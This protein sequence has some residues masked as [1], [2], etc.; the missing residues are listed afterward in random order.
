MQVQENPG[1]PS[2][3][4]APA[5]ATPAA[6]TPAAA[7]PAAAATPDPN[8]PNPAP[9]TPAAAEQAPAPTRPDWAPETFWDATK[10]ELKGEDIGKI[11]ASHAERQADVITDPTKATIKSDLKGKDGKPI[12][13]NAESPL[14][15]AAA[16]MGAKRGWTNGDLS[17]MA[18]I[19]A[20]AQMAALEAEEADILALGNGDRSKADQRLTA[21]LTKG[22]ALIGADEQGNVSPDATKA[23]STLLASI[24]SRAEFETLEKLI[25]AAGGPNAA[26]AGGGGQVTDIAKRWYPN[27]AKKAG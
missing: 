21:V 16:E 25:N 14:L 3:T 15:K 18:E 20:T 27:E 4:P 8:N 22:A 2:A 7:T 11:L 9:A 1:N 26:A 6:A 17:A 12:E 13:F 5:P 10:G 19:V 24:H 23:L